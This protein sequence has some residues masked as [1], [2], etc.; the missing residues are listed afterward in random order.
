MAG[1]HRRREGKEVWPGAERRRREGNGRRGGL[2][3]GKLGFGDED[4]CIY[5][6]WW[7]LFGSYYFF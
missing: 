4:V 2:G 1:H 6:E 7:G 5:V 3:D